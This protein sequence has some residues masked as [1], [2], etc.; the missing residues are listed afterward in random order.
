MTADIEMRLMTNVF[1]YLFVY[2]FIHLRCVDI[3]SSSIKQEIILW[4]HIN[5]SDAMYIDE[6]TDRET[7]RPINEILVRA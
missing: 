7:D 2:L 1:S 4:E 5:I 3:S 6:Q